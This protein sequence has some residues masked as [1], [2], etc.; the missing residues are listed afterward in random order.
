MAARRSSK[1]NLFEYCQKR[2][3]GPPL[4]ENWAA[5]NGYQAKVLIDGYP[6]PTSAVCSKKKDAEHDAAKAC[7]A[8]LGIFEDDTGGPNEFNNQGYP[9]DQG[10]PGGQDYPDGQ[11]YPGANR[12]GRSS[13]G[14]PSG[15]SPC[16]G[17]STPSPRPFDRPPRS[18]GSS[19]GGVKMPKS[20]LHEFCQSQKMSLPQYETEASYDGSALLGF[21]CVLVVTDEYFTTDRLYTNKREAEHA[22]ARKALNVFGYYA[23]SPLY[24][25]DTPPIHQA[26]GTPSFKTPETSYKNLLQEH[27]QQRSI[28]TPDYETQLTGMSI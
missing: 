19:G 24:T 14:T 4:F 1:S 28:E 23:R 21:H 7:L 12:N 2:K 26:V 15:P 8:S 10:Y 3:I 11:S 5:P 25:G 16:S 13:F 18:G 6:Y 27:L 9:G 22:V 20:V 17:F